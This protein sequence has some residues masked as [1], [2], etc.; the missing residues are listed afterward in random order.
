MQQDLETL[1]TNPNNENHFDF[2]CV[3]DGKCP[4]STLMTKLMQLMQQVNLLENQV[5]KIQNQQ[6]IFTIQQ[7]YCLVNLDKLGIP[8]DEQ[9]IKDFNDWSCGNHY[10]L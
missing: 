10:D 4:F 9:S 7:E 5:Q 3:N 2:S 6:E 1:G 8:I